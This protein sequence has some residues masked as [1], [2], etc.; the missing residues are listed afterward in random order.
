M[1]IYFTGTG[2]S[3]YCARMIAAGLDDELVSA[4]DFIKGGSRAELHSEKPW[5]FVSPT[6][7]WQLPHVFESFIRESK[8]RGSKSAYFVMTCGSEI[9]NAA[10][11]IAPLCEEIGLD[12]RGVLQVVMPENYIAMFSVP[13]KSES[14]R[15]IKAARPTVETGIEYILKGEPF[16]TVKCGVLDRLKT[17]PV[18]SVFYRFFI[19]AAPFY[20]TDACVGCGKC[21]D[22][23]MLN[24]ITLENGRPVWADRCTHCMACICGCPTEAIEYGRHSRGKPRYRCAEYK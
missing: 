16:P 14:D 6:Y 2:N 20:A 21:A 18:N 7:A 8:L 13:G 4:F 12:Y 23:C 22:L 10:S 11:R 15:I 3:R 1:V 24:N 17:G 19:K 5:V 9:G